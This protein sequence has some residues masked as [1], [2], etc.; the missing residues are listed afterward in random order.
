[1][2][3]LQN[4]LANTGLYKFD[5]PISNGELQAYERQLNDLFD[6]QQQMKREMA[7]DTTELLIQR[8]EKIYAVKNEAN[9][10]I[11][12]RQ[13]KL[14][15]KRRAK[16]VLTPAKVLLFANDFGYEAKVIKHV[17]PFCYWVEIKQSDFNAYKLDQLLM[18]SE[19]GHQSHEFGFTSKAEAIQISG[20]TRT[21]SIEYPVCGMFFAEDD[22]E[23]RIYKESVIVGEATWLHTVD[24]PLT[25]TFY[26]VLE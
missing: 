18:R 11:R 10:S 2:F 25:N 22:L 3:D 24:Y 21:N 9:D 16:G 13:I 15:Q 5:D 17:R 23:G 8:W 14:L 26:S 4:Q 1:M 12:D 6:W 19:P 7:L 20:K